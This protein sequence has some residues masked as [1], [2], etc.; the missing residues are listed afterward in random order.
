MTVGEVEDVD[1]PRIFDNLELVLHPTLDATLANSSRADFCVGYFNL[2]GWKLIDS[3]IDAW[4]G[5]PDNRCRLLVGMQRLPQDELRDML[6]ADSA[7]GGIDLQTANALRRRVAQEFRQQLT[8]GNPSNSDEKG[9]RRLSDQLRAGKVQ[10]KLYLRETLHAKLYLVHREDMNN[11]TIGFVGSSNLTFSGLKNQGEL[12]VDVLDH[13]ACRKLTSWF[14][15]RWEDNFCVDITEDLADIIDESWA[16]PVLRDPYHIYVKMAYHL[17]QEARAGLSEYGV[18][19]DLRNVLLDFQAAAVR[20]AAHHLNHRGGVIIG[21]VVGLG[22]TLMA[23]ALARLFQ[24][25]QFT[26]TLIIC[27]ARLVRMWE[28][29]VH[30]Y[31]LIARVVSLGNVQ[32]VLPT[33]QRYRVVLIDESHNLRNREGSRYRIIRD[34][35]EQNDSRCILLSATP[36]N[37]SYE[38]LGSQL[39]LFVPENQDLGVRPERLIREMGEMEFI[40]KYQAAPRTIAA[41]EKSPYPD[42]WRDLMRLYLVRRTRSFIEENYAAADP[43]TGRM[44]LSF[45]DGSRHVFPTRVP[46]NVAPTPVTSEEDDPYLRMYSDSVIDVVD[47]LKLPRYGM[48]SY[49]APESAFSPTEG[50]VRT[51]ARL[52]RAGARL[53]G[54]VRTNLFKR[55]ESGGPSFLLSVY[56]HVL[57]NEVLVYALENGLPIP[58]GAQDATVLDTDLTDAD[59]NGEGIRV[60]EQVDYSPAKIRQRARDLYRE[61]SGSQHGR[62]RWLPAEAFRDELR[63][64]LIADADGLAGLLR[65]L[66][67]W[68]PEG[69]AKLLALHRLITEVHPKEKVLVFTQF[70]DTAV[71][72]QRELR[73]LVDEKAR[74][75]IVAVTGNDNDPTSIAWRFSPKSNDAETTDG[76]EIRVLLATDVLSEGQNLQDAHI[77]VNYDLPWA[78]IRL[79][80]RAGRVDRLGQEAEEILAYSFLP[81]D[82]VEQLLRLR[83]RVRQRLLE[84]AAVLG[85]DETF[86]ED[87]PAS[88]PL[89]DLYNEKAGVLDG[90]ADTEVDLASYA[91]QIWKNAIDEDP[92]LAQ[93]IPSL[94]A[95]VYATRRL[96]VGAGEVK[97]PG[98]LVFVRTSADNDALAYVSDRGEILSHSQLGILKAAE[99]LPDTA[100]QPRAEN[101]H[102]LVEQ[103][104]EHLS[105]EER[106]VG[107]QLGRPSGARFR[108]YERLKR[109][110]E[111]VRG[112]LFETPELLK[113]LEDIYRHPLQQT[114]TDTI[115]RQ[116]RAGIPDHQLAELLVALRDDGRLSVIQDNVAQIGPEI[117]CSMGLVE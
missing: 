77:I 58:I 75:E 80:Q 90:D 45:P 102:E 105:N 10:V 31:G 117:L 32:N 85:T 88:M 21:D 61:F 7:S 8:M 108:C 81:A 20:I 110:S 87:D 48:T 27:P 39:R 29:Y 47:A 96:T 51:I 13:D 56:R 52:S 79:I 25:D 4:A 6:R 97:S 92:H 15:D 9:L 26:N 78:I 33:L 2:R 100:P 36:Y 28:S 64:D 72:L 74:P 37:K 42:D 60:D 54:F 12:N 89:E 46:R 59:E 93:L 16:S 24:E 107:G 19:K 63:N 3:R 98:A 94:P 49:L 66:G 69:D 84:N 116:L 23:V 70:A 103:A 11:P 1:V 5:T 86:F 115:N 40:R 17:S 65:E 44:F 82:G 43:K 14:E 109:H 83:A 38:D 71:Y 111:N 76:H 22:K 67:D 106:A 35:I 57:R 34:Y 55:L 30:K 53:M 99:C 95:V 50:E 101:H 73:S 104:V 112:T 91:Y 113:T 41:F 68:R 18:P 62:F 114:A